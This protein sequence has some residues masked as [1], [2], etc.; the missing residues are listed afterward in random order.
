MQIIEL[1]KFNL[2]GSI[3]DIGSK[4]SLSNIT[5]FIDYNKDITYLDK[6]SNNPEDLKIDL[7]NEYNN[8]ENI[9][10]DNVILLNVLEHIYNYQNC[11]N[12]SNFFLKKNGI[13]LGSTPFYFQVHGSP[14]D[15]FRFTSE[16]LIKILNKSGF[17]EIEIKILAGGVF[18]CFFNSI[19]RMTQKIPF[20]NNA[21]FLICQFFDFVI[22][23]FS[24][25]LNLMF[26]LGYFFKGRK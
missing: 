8:S 26:P 16:A 1:K 11:M 25:N 5:N 22:S 9:K 2:K 3:L 4:K 7:E 14:K 6:Y 12:T 19:S 21:I 15:Y 17:N 13:I 20:L 23:F 24:K 18:I 10:F